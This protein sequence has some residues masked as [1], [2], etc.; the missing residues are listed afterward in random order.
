MASVRGRRGATKHS[1]EL[2]CDCC[3]CADP[4]CVPVRADAGAKFVL[5][6]SSSLA[7]VASKA[8]TL[9]AGQAEL[10][11]LLHSATLGLALIKEK[12]GSVCDSAWVHSNY[13]RLHHAR[14]SLR[15]AAAKRKHA[16]AAAIM[17]DSAAERPASRARLEALN[18]AVQGDHAPRKT[19][20]LAATVLR[21][22]NRG[23]GTAALKGKRTHAGI[24][25]AAPRLGQAMASY[26][27]GAAGAATSMGGGLTLPTMMAQYSA[28]APPATKFPA[29]MSAAAA[30][31]ADS[32]IELIVARRGGAFSDDVDDPAQEAQDAM[33]DAEEERQAALDRPTQSDQEFIDDEPQEE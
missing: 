12:V 11:K 29:G 13:V 17:E 31:A 4:P 23:R 25:G 33:E 6:D 19:D 5:G 30:A 15:E 22:K 8:K 14:E 16:R 3:T 24:S 26:T 7:G 1:H 10:E 32:R 18:T 2:Y 28:A 27:A 9:K 21:F 20:H